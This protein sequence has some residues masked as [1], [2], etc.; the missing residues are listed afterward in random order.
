MIFFTLLLHQWKQARRSPIW[1]KN[2]AVNLIMGFFFMII[3]LEFVILSIFLADKWHE[4]TD[5]DAPV[6]FFHQILAWYFAAMVSFRFF[7][8]KLAAIEARPYL[9]LP[10]R[11]SSLIHYLLFR[12]SIN[13]F[14]LLTIIVI[15]P[16]SIFQVAYGRPSYHA[17]IWVVGMLSLDLTINF[18]VLYFK[19]QLA[20]NVKVALTFIAFI[21]LSAL[22]EYLG[23]FSFSKFIASG[24]DLMLAWPAL[25]L[26]PILVLAFT[27]L[28]NFKFLQKGM[29]LEAYQPKSERHALT[30]NI[31]YLDK[32]GLMGQLISM[33]IKLQMRN[34]R[35][36]SMLMMAPLFLLYGLFFYPSGQYDTDGGFAVFV[37]VFTSSGIAINLL[38]YAFAY[39]GSFFDLLNTL[40][41]RKSD[42]V[43]AKMLLGSSVVIV[44][45]LVTIP[46][47]YFGMDVFIIHS[48]SAL[49][50][51]G[52]IVPGL[53]FFATYN[54]KTMVLSRGTAFN[55]QGVGAVHFMVMIPV[56]VLPVM[57]YLPFKWFGNPM[58]GVI[59]LGA[60][61]LLGLIL[62]NWFIKIISSNLAERKYV[63][64]EGFR[65]KE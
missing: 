43:K 40:S 6:S 25:V 29:Y 32:I 51:L 38:Q 56:L 30:G 35:T 20:A 11:K 61:G 54:K 5:S 58:G 9:H 4:I 64:A 10:V 15:V 63:M 65:Q 33:D 34:K 52:L 42:L 53:L 2:L 24:F 13:F 16:F 55:Y 23:W 60:F 27:Y 36:K 44:S 48:A 21:V 7:M 26:L 39:E 22:T 57:I 12:S 1:Q 47:I 62:R 31:R 50:S 17:I 19:K 59:A 41:I 8:Q 49:F 18:I 28:L 3:F 14:N 45:Y 37:G 46:Y